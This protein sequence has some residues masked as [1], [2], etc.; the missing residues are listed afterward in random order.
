MLTAAKTLRDDVREDDARRLLSIL[1]EEIAR[2][3]RIVS[4]ILTRD[5]HAAP[6]GCDLAVLTRHVVE[7]IEAGRGERAIPVIDVR[8]PA[9]LPVQAPADTLKQVIWNVLR[10]ACEAAGPS[11]HVWVG[12]RQEA[13][14]AILEVDDDGPGPGGKPEGEGLGLALCEQLVRENGGSLD[15]SASPRGGARLTIRIPA[16]RPAEVPA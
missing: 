9:S 14:R 2:L 1:T 7:L 10:N 6:A 4:A 5:A 12:A 16:S 3:D 11:G 15:L 13:E 8:L